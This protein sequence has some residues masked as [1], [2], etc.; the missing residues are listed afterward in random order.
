MKATIVPSNVPQIHQL[1]KYFE[2]TWINGFWN[3]IHWCQYFQDIRTNNDTEGYHH[4]LNDKCQ[5]PNMA[6]SSLVHVLHEEALDV[7]TT[8]MQVFY[9]QQSRKRKSAA[10]RRQE[11][12]DRLNRL[13]QEEDITPLQFV[14]RSVIHISPS[15]YWATEESRADLDEDID[16]PEFEI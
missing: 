9:G 11:H 4:K 1:V 8:V 16:D 12:L 5:R 10:V 15:E 13:L 3:P 14:E 7:P 2:D 6:F